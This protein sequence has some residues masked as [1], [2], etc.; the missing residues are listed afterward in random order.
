MVDASLKIITHKIE[1]DDLQ[2]RIDHIAVDGP[3]QVIYCP[4][5]KEDI[6]SIFRMTEDI[7]IAG[8]YSSCVLEEG[9]YKGQKYTYHFFASNK[10]THCFTQEELVERVCSGA[11]EKAFKQ[12][13]KEAPEIKIDDKGRVIH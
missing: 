6:E 7:Y 12:K 11:E 2:R 4:P 1:E 9:P 8:V 13:V 5:T 10:V 3:I